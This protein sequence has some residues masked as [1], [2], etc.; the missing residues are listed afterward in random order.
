MLKTRVMPCLLLRNGALV[1][2]IKFD[3][4]NYIGDPI[5][6][7]RIY[8]EKEVDEL[9]F[10]DITATLEKRKPNFKLVSEI[11]SECFMPLAYGGGVRTI[12]DLMELFKI[13]VEKVVINSYAAENSEFIT[14]AANLFGS[15]SIIVSIDL[16]KNSL[17]QYQVYTNSGKKK[18]DFHP[19]E[20]AIR[21]QEKGAG[22]IFLTSID[23]DGTWEGYDIDLIRQITEDISIPVIASGGAGKIDDL[24]KAVQVGGASAVAAGSMFVYQGKDLG[25]LIKFPQK[26]ELKKLP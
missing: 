4:F 24:L 1:K 15:Q 25:V 20:Y 13:G 5:N 10:L 16:K 14:E 18:T 8:N 17:G 7:V 26:S 12:E 23:R 6:A 3:K 9:I 22:E 2:T 21:M 11:A 19:V